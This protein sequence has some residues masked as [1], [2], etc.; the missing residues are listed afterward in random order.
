MM[1]K[2]SPSKKR[3][4]R[5]PE[6][7]GSGPASGS[8]ITGEKCLLVKRLIF[9][10][11]LHP[12]QLLMTFKP[13]KSAATTSIAKQSVDSPATNPNHNSDLGSTGGNA[14]IDQ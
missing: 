11:H 1:I 7:S 9:P 8:R 3:D 2:D 14:I 6:L 4:I 12:S 10:H 13:K 5:D